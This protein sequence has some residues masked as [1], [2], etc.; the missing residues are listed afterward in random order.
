[1]TFE[2]L[3]HQSREEK[4]KKNLEEQKREL[5]FLEKNIRGESSQMLQK[6]AQE[7]AQE[8]GI[9]ISQA[10][11]L[12]NGKTESGLDILKTSLKQ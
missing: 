6:L 8:F 3:D 2:Q 7:I 9:D 12:I 11:E 1:M 5:F 4:K 10:K